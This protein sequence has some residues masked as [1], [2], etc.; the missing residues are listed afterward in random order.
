VSLALPPE[1]FALEV[2]RAEDFEELLALRLRAMRPSLEKLGRYD[3]QRARARLA[4]G[5]EAQ[6]TQHIVVDGSRVGFLVLKH[7]ARA[8]RLEHL[9]VDPTAQ[10]QGIGSRVMSWVKS[11]A[12]RAGLPIELVALKASE[13][14]R[15]YLRQGFVANGESAWDTNYVW[16][17]LSDSVQTV[18]SMWS[19]FQARD[20]PGARFWLADDFEARWWA[21]GERFT[22]A[23]GFIE[24]QSSYPEGWTIRLIDCVGLADG[25]VLS[26]VRVEHPPAIFFAT[27][28]FRLQGSKIEAI[29][30]FWATVEEPPA[31]R[32]ALDARGRQ[33]FD[34]LEDPR[35]VLP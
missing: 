13:S 2:A 30:E 31:W 9:Y 32:D 3:E 21:S 23:D 28:F 1:G 15:F 11:Q 34:P 19:S 35:A 14:N 20:W 12:Q 10:R 29:D 24:A 18:R 22:S 17:P 26:T 27:S 33:R 4:D 16:L 25:R 5:F 6:Q 7:S 8:L